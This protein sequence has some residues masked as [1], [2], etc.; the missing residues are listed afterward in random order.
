MTDLSV[1][2]IENPLLKFSQGWLLLSQV[3]QR[4]FETK[5][6]SVNQY[7]I[8]APINSRTVGASTRGPR[9]EF[10]QAKNPKR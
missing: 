9:P 6:K 1:I 7:A 8:V 4:L 3:M 10:F 5:A 2:T